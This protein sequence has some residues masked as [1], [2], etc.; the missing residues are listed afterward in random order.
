MLYSIILDPT[1][2]TI[3]RSKTLRAL[4]R[5]AELTKPKSVRCDRALLMLEITYTNRDVGLAHFPSYQAMMQWVQTRHIFKDAAIV[6]DESQSIR[7]TER[8]PAAAILDS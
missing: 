3:H 6:S 5:H 7:S 1:G 4:T 2:L 8:R